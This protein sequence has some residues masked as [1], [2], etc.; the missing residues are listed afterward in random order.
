MSY[1]AAYFVLL[2][3]FHLSLAIKLQLFK[4][5]II[6]NIIQFIFIGELLF[7]I[8]KKSKLFGK[9][10]CVSAPFLFLI[11][12]LVP[13][14]ALVLYAHTYIKDFKGTI[15]I[16]PKYLVILVLSVSALVFLILEGEILHAY[17][18]YH[19]YLSQIIVYFL[20]VVILLPAFIIIIHPFKILKKYQYILL[21]VF[22]IILVVINPLLGKTL[23]SDEEIK[24]FTFV[25]EQTPEDAI[26]L[27]PVSYD[28]FRLGVDRAIVVDF[29]TIPFRED[30]MVEWYDRILTTTNNE[31]LAYTQELRKNTG[32]KLHT[33]YHEHNTS[34]INELKKN[35]S[36]NYLISFE[37][38][39]LNYEPIYSTEN[40]YVYQVI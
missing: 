25:R 19:S 17:A 7:N 26:F 22:I 31:K 13:I 37:D 32:Q 36:F 6:L 18:T 15:P 28:D 12:P 21:S 16:K 29:K 38:L 23:H 34:S 2:N 8:Y 30:Q 35:Y 1:Y 3:I 9:I 40:Y 27:I 11:Y 5:I 14:Y 20:K 39:N 24:L 10:I 4:S 33:G